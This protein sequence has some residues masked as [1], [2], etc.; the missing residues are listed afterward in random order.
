[1]IEQQAELELLRAAEALGERTP[2]RLQRPA[3]Q[4]PCA[5]ACRGPPR[6]CDD[7]CVVKCDAKELLHHFGLT[8]EAAK[9]EKPR[10][11]TTLPLKQQKVNYSMHAI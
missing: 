2:L 10:V 8:C 5:E 9:E 1:M 11:E 4:P 3:A 6:D 7:S